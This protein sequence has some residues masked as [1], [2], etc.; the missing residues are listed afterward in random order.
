MKYLYRIFAVLSI[1]LLSILVMFAYSIRKSG[2]NKG[3]NKL[4]V[5]EN[6]VQKEESVKV[7]DGDNP[8]RVLVLGVDKSATKDASAEENGMRTDTM[9]LF[10]IDPKYNKVQIVSIPRD[11]YIRIHGFDKN[12]V[13]AAFNDKVYPGGG[14]NLTVETIQ[15]FFDIKIDHY[16]IVDYK[17]VIDIVDAVGGMD[18]YW[19]HQDYHYVDNWVVPPLVVDLKHGENHLDGV[20][21][22]AYLRTRKVYKNQDIGRIG[23]QQD[24][25]LS[26]F[27]KLQSPKMIVKI[28][29]LVDIVGEYVET[30]L[31]LGEISKLAYYGLGLKRD[32]IYTA[33]VDGY[34]KMMKQGKHDLSFWIVNQ[35]KAREL[36][37]GFPEREIKQEEEKAKQQQV[38]E[39][40]E[41][42]L[43]DNVT[44]VRKK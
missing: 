37:H 10:T 1:L 16:A 33:T 43:Q 22:V 20:A 27:E 2:Q 24:F 12:K 35:E 8:L 40:K 14:L 17:A 29:K 11:S 9:M 44:E 41:K 25:L 4:H 32:D 30:D 18:V 21:A 23:V 28:P 13:N 6:K 42:N 39:D 15:D 5:G 38:D 31:N 7:F 36:V 3:V 19:D 26:M 34:P